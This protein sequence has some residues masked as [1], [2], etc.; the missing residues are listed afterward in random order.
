MANW[1]EQGRWL[2]PPPWWR[3]DGTTLIATS[4]ER[5][6]FWRKTHYGFVRDNGHVFALTAPAEFTAS[7]RVEGAFAE[8]YDQAGLMLRW[9]ERCWVKAGAEFTDDALHL[10]TV[11]TNEQSD[12]SVSRSLG[13]LRSFHLRVTVM[14]GAMRVQASGDGQAWEL[15]R[16][17]PL[18]SDR[19]P[20]Q[21]GPMFCSPERE[22]LEVRFSEFLLGPPIQNDLRDPS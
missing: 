1:L 17:A 20:W 13:S 18:P 10:S 7:V 11:I 15:I 9:D 5:T 2:N 22:G 14:G 16:L 8:L 3:V 21:I 19:E 6:D 4:G 12:W